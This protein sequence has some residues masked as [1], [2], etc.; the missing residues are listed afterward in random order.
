MTETTAAIILAQL[1]L[2]RVSLVDVKSIYDETGSAVAVLDRMKETVKGV[3]Y[4]SLEKRAEQE[5]QWCANNKVQILLISDERYP[6]RLSHCSDAP[7]VLFNRG[8][9]DFNTQHV[10][11]IVG[12]RKCTTYGQDCID[13]IVNGLHQMIP[14]LAIVSGLAYGVDITAHRAAMRNEI[15]TAGVVAHGQDM[16][17]PASHRTEANKMVLGQGA[18]LTEYLSGI[19]PEARNFLQRNRI[20]AGM[21]D[22]VIVPESAERGGSLATARLAMEYG[23][24]VF[25]VP[26]AVNAEYSKGCNNL[27]RDNK[28]ALIT[29]AKD[30]ADA[31]GWQMETE[32]QDARRKGIE[33]SL[34]VELTPNEQTIVDALTK[35]GDMQVNA[36]TQVTG[37]PFANVST[38]LFSLEMKGVIKPLSGNVFHLIN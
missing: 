15:P 3:D 27:I 4:G 9:M 25:A 28:A 2:N 30:V 23:R 20:I 37:M 5:Q 22:A 35:N 1:T 10:V 21:C 34:F 11:A 14:D 13:S 33:R 31:M 7:L 12:T 32:L 6:Q 26:G 8:Q 16:L 38:T 17:Y 24:D 29:S 18:V 19:R 36:I